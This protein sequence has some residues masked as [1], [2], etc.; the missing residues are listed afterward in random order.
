MEKTEKYKFQSIDSGNCRAYYKKGRNL[1][2]IQDDGAWG[3]RELRFY[4]CSR[5]GEPSHNV[6]FPTKSEFDRYIEP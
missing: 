1:Y 4:F 2:C 6:N 3:K 5:D